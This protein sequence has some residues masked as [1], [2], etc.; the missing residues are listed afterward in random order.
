MF[1]LQFLFKWSDLHLLSSLF[2]MVNTMFKW[3]DILAKFRG[4]Y[5]TRPFIIAI[6]RNSEYLPTTTFCTMSQE[7]SLCCDYTPFNLVDPDNN[8]V[9]YTLTGRPRSPDLH[10]ECLD[11]FCTELGYRNLTYLKD[12]CTTSSNTGFDTTDRC[13]SGIGFKII[14]ATIVMLLQHIIDNKLKEECEGCAT[15]H[16]SQLQHSCLFE[17]Y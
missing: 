9:N 5:H 2:S 14:K 13:L 3:C 17:P 6:I 15:D 7:D 11:K 12:L 4:C 10:K 8:A 1:T 16:P